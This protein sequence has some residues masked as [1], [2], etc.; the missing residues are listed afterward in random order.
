MQRKQI[1]GFKCPSNEECRTLYLRLLE[2]KHF[3]T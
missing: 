3:F 1:V 2:Q